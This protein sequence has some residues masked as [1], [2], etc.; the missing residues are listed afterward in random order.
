VESRYCL[1]QKSGIEA[2]RQELKSTET[3]ASYRIFRDHVLSDK[4]ISVFDEYVA[5][6]VITVR[7]E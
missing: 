2:F 6:P 1:V 7:V 3:S 5:A 4:Q